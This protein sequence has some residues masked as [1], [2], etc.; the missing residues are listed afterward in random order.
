[1]AEERKSYEQRAEIIAKKLLSKIY[2]LESRALEAKLD[3]IQ[4]KDKLE[5]QVKS[6]VQQREELEKKYYDLVNASE[7][8][9]QNVSEDF[10]TLINSISSDKQDFY[11]RAQGWL[12]DFNGKISDLEEKARN[13]SNEIR[14]SVQ[15]QVNNL[16][17]QR[18][19]LQKNLVDMQHESGERWKSFRDGVDEGLNSMKTRI[20]KVYQYFQRPREE[21]DTSSK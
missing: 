9:W 14:T 12:N 2:A 3:A 13:S 4:N 11:E 1:M 18:E 21:E 19:R 15:D 8:Q 16:R 17:E 20:N 5:E 6:L 10:E 7:S